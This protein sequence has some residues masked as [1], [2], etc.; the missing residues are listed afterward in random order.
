MTD[1][2]LCVLTPQHPTECQR[3]ECIFYIENECV[4]KPADRNTSIKKFST[5]ELVNEITTRSE[6]ENCIISPGDGLNYVNIFLKLPQGGH[7]D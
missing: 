3:G 1:K 5:A 6:L 4:C 2:I 7:H